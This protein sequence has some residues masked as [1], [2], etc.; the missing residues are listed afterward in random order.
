MK[1]K[2]GKAF[3]VVVTIGFTVD[4]K[5]SISWWRKRRTI[6]VPP[7]VGLVLVDE[8]TYSNSRGKHF[9][10]KDIGVD[11]DDVILYCGSIKCWDV[12]NHPKR[13]MDAL[14]YEQYV[15]HIDRTD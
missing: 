4:P 2:K 15:P 5:D 6:P 13:V 9:T 3:P 11:G 1:P 10:V 8:P 7:V 12:F 14:G